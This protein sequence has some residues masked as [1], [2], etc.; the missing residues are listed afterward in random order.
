MRFFISIVPL[1]STSICI[2]GK[3]EYWQDSV[4]YKLVLS[5]QSL[6]IAFTMITI[7][8][9]NKPRGFITYNDLAMLFDFKYTWLLYYNLLFF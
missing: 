4:I 2:Y 6:Y 3:P 7:K 5:T 8:S 9:Y 1:T